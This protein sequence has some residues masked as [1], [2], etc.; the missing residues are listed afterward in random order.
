MPYIY[1]I[2]NDINGKIYIG[3]THN[4]IETRFKQH[5]A[6]S[7]KGSCKN[8][9]LYR[10][11]N[12]YGIEHF[13]I[14]LI[15]ETDTPE[16]R[17]IYWIEQYNSYREGYNA[18]IGG[19]GKPY[20]DRQMVKSLYKKL[21]SCTEVAK[22]MKIDKGT[23]SKILKELNVEIIANKKV[24]KERY[25]NPVLMLNRQREIIKIF[26]SYSEAGR[27]LQLM[28]ITKDKKLKGIIGH[29]GAVCSG[30]RKTAY[31]FIWEKVEIPPMSTAAT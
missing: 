4:S 23:V 5:C 8:R 20:I 18:T 9:P 31:G 13:H 21:R 29:I 19:D 17:E 22:I 15:E 10:A 7:I 16:E 30:K 11:M 14:E 12:K 27:Y 28:N 24:V 6:D 3:K 2:T 26:P 25:S 1:K